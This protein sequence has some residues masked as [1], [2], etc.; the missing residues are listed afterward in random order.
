MVRYNSSHRDEPAKTV[1]RGFVTSLMYTQLWKTGGLTRHALRQI[2]REDE[3]LVVQ[4]KNRP[5]YPLTATE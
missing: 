1:R 2:G 3:M 5:V 4:K